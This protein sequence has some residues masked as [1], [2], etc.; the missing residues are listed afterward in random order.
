MKAIVYTKYGPPDVLE[1]REVE[2]PSPTDNEVLIKI[3][4]TTVGAMDWRFR[5]GK[6]PIARVLAGLTKPRNPIFGI[7]VA[8]RSRS[9]RR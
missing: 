4:A 6:N 7:D 2:K 8:R 3:H 1:L 9:G 5:Q